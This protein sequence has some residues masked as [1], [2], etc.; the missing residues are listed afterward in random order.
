M[1]VHDVH[2][3]RGADVVRCLLFQERSAFQEDFLSLYGTYGTKVPAVH[4]PGLAQAR[5]T[6]RLT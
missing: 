3:S 2:L 5:S 1:E 6:V 4:R